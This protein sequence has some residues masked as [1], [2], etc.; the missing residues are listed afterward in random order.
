MELTRRNLFA[1]AGGVIAAAA[2]NPTLSIAAPYQF[3]REN[4]KAILKH[5][6]GYYRHFPD[7]GAHK[8][9]KA[10]LFMEP[11]FFIC[12]T[13]T[14]PCVIVYEHGTELR[15]HAMP[16][17]L[18]NFKFHMPLERLD[19]WRS[20]GEGEATKLVAAELLKEWKDEQYRTRAHY[21]AIKDSGKP[22]PLWHEGFETATVYPY[23]INMVR[24]LRPD[25]FRPYFGFAGRYGIGPGGYLPITEKEL[26][27]ALAAEVRQVN[28]YHKKLKRE[29]VI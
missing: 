28:A 24:A 14:S 15:K 25:T 9:M 3:D 11:E 10:M 6:E 26:K 22:M 2:I 7:P 1:G 4:V 23:G 19:E 27:S 18:R 17:K 29:G 8:V 20:M 16:A 12:R 21:R 5:F 13:M